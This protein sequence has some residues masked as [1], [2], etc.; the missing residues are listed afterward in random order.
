MSQGE[1]VKSID[2]VVKQ[3]GEHGKKLR[4]V[5]RVGLAIGGEE[6][7]AGV[8]EILTSRTSADN[9][10]DATEQKRAQLIAA[11]PDLLEACKSLEEIASLINA[12][13]H[14]DAPIRPDD[15]SELYHCCNQAK[16][17]LAKAT[18]EGAK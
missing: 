12:R 18:K 15:W 13:Q 9:F 8:C 6:I 10:S 14:A 17:A 16:A 1:T 7:L 2:W 11:A 3:P 5:E 4:V